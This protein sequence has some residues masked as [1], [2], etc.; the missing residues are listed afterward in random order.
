VPKNSSLRAQNKTEA[1]C[2]ISRGSTFTFT[3]DLSCIAF[4]L[5]THVHLRDRGKQPSLK[6]LLWNPEPPGEKKMGLNGPYAR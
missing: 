1:M 3:R 2:E 5:F 6:I 4:I